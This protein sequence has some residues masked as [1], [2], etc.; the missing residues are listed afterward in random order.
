MKDIQQTAHGKTRTQLINTYNTASLHRQSP[1]KA[2][3]MPHPP[4]D[5]LNLPQ[6]NFRSTKSPALVS[7]ERNLQSISS[8]LKEQENY[9][10]FFWTPDM[11]VCGF[12]TANEIKQTLNMLRVDAD[13]TDKF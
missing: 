3:P 13:Y 1:S 9:K 10:Q 5:L 11:S 8:K 12:G 2:E 7:L 6:T 4:Q